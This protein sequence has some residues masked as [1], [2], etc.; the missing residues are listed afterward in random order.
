MYICSM[1]VTERVIENEEWVLLTGIF[2]VSFWVLAKF[3]NTDRFASFLSFFSS[4][5]Y[6]QER[7]RE[8][9]WISPTELILL[10]SGF[11]CLSFLAFEI[12]YNQQLIHERSFFNYLK[13]ASLL[14]GFVAAKNFLLKITFFFFDIEGY[15]KWYWFYKLTGFIWASN[16]LF[17]FYLWTFSPYNTASILVFGSSFL[18]M[19]TYAWFIVKIYKKYQQLIINQFLYF[20]LY[21]CA[22]EIAPY[23]FAY[24]MIG[25]IKL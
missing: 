19:F 16:L 13:V 24:K 10:A 20:I 22:L 7:M 14:L 18:L 5:K 9:K 23:I 12:A 21:L 1:N 4:E 11:T 8:S 25:A 3:L 17:I 6:T 2:I 15:F